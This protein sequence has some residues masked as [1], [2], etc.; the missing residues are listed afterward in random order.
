MKIRRYFQI[1]TLRAVALCQT[2]QIMTH[3]TP[4]GKLPMDLALWPTRELLLL[5]LR[6][7]SLENMLHWKMITLDRVGY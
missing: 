3:P 7:A 5:A 6:A 4:N 1:L 2:F